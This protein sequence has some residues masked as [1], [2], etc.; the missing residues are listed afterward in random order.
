MIVLEIYQVKVVALDI[1]A[2]ATMTALFCGHR[3]QFG[4]IL[5]KPTLR[6]ALSMATK[7]RGRNSRN[8]RQ[9]ERYISSTITVSI[10]SRASF[11]RLKTSPAPV[12]IISA[13]RPVFRNLALRMMPGI[14]GMGS[15]VS[16]QSRM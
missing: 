3:G 11:G 9:E 7:K 15:S 13:F 6:K 5:E 12:S 1:P 4:A 16:C 10:G 8:T 14:L 2:L